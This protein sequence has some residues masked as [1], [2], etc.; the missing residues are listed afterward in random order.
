MD[1]GSIL[2]GLR[3]RERLIIVAASHLVVNHM[4]DVLIEETHGTIT[5]DEVC[6]TGMQRAKA[7]GEVPVVHV[8][9]PVQTTIL[10]RVEIRQE[11]VDRDDGG[12]D[13]DAAVRLCPTGVRAGAAVEAERI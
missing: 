5:E 3:K 8:D 2:D 13:G 4:A 7:E 10:S 1:H 9:L 6:A 11:R 12:I